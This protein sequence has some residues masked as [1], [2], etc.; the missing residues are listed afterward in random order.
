MIRLLLSLFLVSSVLAV[1][2]APG[3]TVAHSPAETKAFIGSPSLLVLHTG[4]YLAA[5]DL[6]GH[7]VCSGSKIYSSLDKGLTW[8]LQSSIPDQMWSNLFLHHGKLYF[9]GTQIKKGHL[10]IRCSEDAGRSW[11]EPCITTPKGI[12]AATAPVTMCISQGRLWRCAE[13]SEKGFNFAK[14]FRPFLISAAVDADLMKPESWMMTNIITPNFKWLGSQFGGWLEGN[15]VDTPNGL[16]CLMRVQ[17]II[18]K[19][20]M[21]LLTTSANGQQLHFAPQTG[22]LPVSG[23]AKK[24][25][26]RPDPKGKGYWALTNIIPAGVDAA[27]PAAI[28]NTLGLLYSPDLKS[29]EARA[30][31]L[32][33]EGKEQYG[34]QYPDFQFDGDD[35]LYLSRTAWHDADNYH[36]ANYLTFHRLKNFRQYTN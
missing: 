26:V 24:F 16:C 29:W 23:G 11:S 14:Q 28:R 20:Y 19:E 27:H 34:F 4:E 8:K 21:A 5:H 18:A 33:H 30:T 32:H 1:E 13:H 25:C 15:V 6:F 10:I 12:R 35:L 22:F 17:T 9:M 7:K 36:N 2:P 3:I 31:L